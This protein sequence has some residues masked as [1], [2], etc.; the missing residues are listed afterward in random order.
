MLSVLNDVLGPADLLDGVFDLTGVDDFL[1]SGFDPF[2]DL[3]AG[4]SFGGLMVDFHPT[5]LG[6]FSDEILLST[7]GYNA[8]GYRGA[9]D[10]ITL[11]IR[12]NVVSTGVPEPS[13]LLLL[14]AAGGA[15]LVASRRR[16]A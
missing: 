6:L 4:D 1:V 2:N 10:D 13:I 7:W 8:S 3:V 12:A 14:F 11:N 16:R 15:L 9:L 5:A